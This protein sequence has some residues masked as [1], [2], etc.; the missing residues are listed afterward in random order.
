MNIYIDYEI[1]QHQF[2]IGKITYDYYNNLSMALNSTKNYISE[3]LNVTGTQEITLSYYLFEEEDDYIL[4]SEVKNIIS[5]TINAD[6]ILIPKIYF[7]DDD[8]ID[9]AAFTIAI[10]KNEKNRSI[11]GGILLGKHYNFNKINAQPYL[12]M[13]LL[14]EI[15][16][17]LGFSSSFF[18][19]FQSYSSLLKTK[20]VNGLKRTLFTGPNVIKQAKRHFNCDN[21]E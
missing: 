2:S 15:T 18:E 5:R 1:L 19:Y 20:T 11:C 16:H 14:H 8:G 6:L 9:A 12:I 4:R 21:I 17:V 3:L 13:L 7:D 10:N